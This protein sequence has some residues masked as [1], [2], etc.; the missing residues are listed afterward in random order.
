MS[1]TATNAPTGTTPSKWDNISKNSRYI[2]FGAL[3]ILALVLL[4]GGETARDSKN[5][6]TKH[7]SSITFGKNKI[8]VKELLR[9]Q[10]LTTIILNDGDVYNHGGELHYV[11]TSKKV[12]LISTS[13]GHSYDWNGWKALGDK[14]TSEENEFQISTDGTVEVTFKK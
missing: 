9:D 7:A 10:S 12:K 5:T 1:Q 2:F 8:D 14:P 6:S 11:H 3:V 4:L 13:T